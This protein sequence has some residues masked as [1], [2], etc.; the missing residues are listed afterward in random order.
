MFLSVYVCSLLF[1]LKQLLNVVQHPSVGHPYTTSGDTSDHERLIRIEKV[2]T[3]RIAKGTRLDT[4]GQLV[5]QGLG[6]P[7]TGKLQG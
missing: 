7:H 5:H 1:T 2:S 3:G 4:L 6:I